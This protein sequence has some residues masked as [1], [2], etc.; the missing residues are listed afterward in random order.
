MN[1]IR[2]INFT[3]IEGTEKIIWR[4]INVRKY[5]VPFFVLLIGLLIVFSHAP[6]INLFFNSYFIILIAAILSPFVLK[7]GYKPF[8]MVA[9]ALFLFSVVIWFYDQDQSE[10]IGNYIFILLF[11]G[12]MRL[13]FSLDKSED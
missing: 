10:M 7:I 9:I 4:W 3:I 12:L 13:I 8:F 5:R 2:K 6:Y 1:M 11:A